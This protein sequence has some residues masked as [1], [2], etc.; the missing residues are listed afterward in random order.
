MFS[1]YK[2]IFQ[3]KQPIYPFQSPPA[4][5]VLLR[6]LQ[7]SI[8][9]L[10]SSCAGPVSSAELGRGACADGAELSEFPASTACPG[11][12]AGLW[13]QSWHPALLSTGPLQ[14]IPHTC[15]PFPF[16]SASNATP[17]TSCGLF[18]LT[19]THEPSH[20]Q[21]LT[22]WAGADTASHGP[23]QLITDTDSENKNKAMVPAPWVLVPHTQKDGTQTEGAKHYTQVVG[24]LLQPRGFTFCS[25]SVKRPGQK[26]LHLQ[27]AQHS[28]GT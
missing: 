8:K 12:Q 19:H 16:H 21:G 6:G 18:T 24:T 2:V 15:I 10:V 23:I 20:G 4:A 28:P 25:S 1:K 7:L 17:N 11:P 26:A 13:G 5:W 27:R 9:T 14:T 3:R 22:N